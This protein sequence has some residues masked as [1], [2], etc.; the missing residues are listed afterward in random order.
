M[1]HFIVTRLEVLL[2]C[3]GNDKQL[4]G[5][6]LKCPERDNAAMREL[7]FF[8]CA[9]WLVAC[10]KQGLG[11]YHC[12]GPRPEAG[13]PLVLQSASI[14]PYLRTV[15]PRPKHNTAE[16]HLQADI[17]FQESNPEYFRA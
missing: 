6:S 17:S 9:P 1:C 11:P 5:P 13:R 12:P 15:D 10:M 4:R 8:F 3:M 2:G 14:G 7:E 16:D